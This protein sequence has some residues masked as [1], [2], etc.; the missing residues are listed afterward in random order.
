MKLLACLNLR[1]R[2]I[3]CLAIVGNMTEKKVYLQRTWRNPEKSVG[4]DQPSLS[5]AS[6]IT[7]HF[8][9]VISR[10]KQV[11]LN[12]K[13]IILAYIV[14]SLHPRILYRVFRLQILRCS[15]N[16]SLI[17]LQLQTKIMSTNEHDINSYRLPVEHRNLIATYIPC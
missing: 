17:C 6:I 12:G 4:S 1:D 13:Y 5:A 3:Y 10:Q 11:V 2:K 14:F 9:F 8:T 15:K 16:M 7:I